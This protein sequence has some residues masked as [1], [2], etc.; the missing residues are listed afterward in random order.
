MSLYS[1]PLPCTWLY[2]A[3]LS[4]SLGVSLANLIVVA[5][6]VAVGHSVGWECG[7]SENLSRVYQLSLSHV[8]LA[9]L[10]H[11]QLLFVMYC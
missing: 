7:C 10:W 5:M 2:C 9:Q 6:A 8:C 3:V 11:M 1:S 4:L